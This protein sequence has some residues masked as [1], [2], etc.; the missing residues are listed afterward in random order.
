ML[1]FA[2]FHPTRGKTPVLDIDSSLT[3]FLTEMDSSP[4]ISNSPLLKGLLV[5]GLKGIRILLNRRLYGYFHCR[6]FPTVFKYAYR[7]WIRFSGFGSVSNRF[8]E[9]TCRLLILSLSS[10]F[11][12]I[13]RPSVTT[14][15]TCV[16]SMIQTALYL[17]RWTIMYAYL[18]FHSNS[19]GSQAG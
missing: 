6:S 14:A 7:L 1:P 16:A 9:K 3:G 10:S 15:R 18:V 19:V 13:T 17:S 4:T 5:E 2:S 8:V 11:P 12:S